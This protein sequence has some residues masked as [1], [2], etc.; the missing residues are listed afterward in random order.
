M[1]FLDLRSAFHTLLREHTFGGSATLPPRL[2]SLLEA[3]GLDAPAISQL[4][5][6]HSSLF[7]RTAR[8]AVIHSLQDAR[9]GTWYTLADSDQCHETLRGSRP[10][11]PLAD[12]AFNT[13]MV[14]VLTEIDEFLQNHVELQRTAE[15]LGIAIPL[16]A[17]ADD[18]SLPVFSLQAAALDHVLVDVVDF[19]HRTVQS[20][21]MRLNYAAGKTETVVFYRGAGSAACRTRRFVQEGGQFPLPSG[22]VLKAVEHYKHLGV[23]FGSMGCLSTDISTRIGKAAATFRQLTRSIFHSRKLKIATRLQLLESLVLSQIFF[24]CGK[25]PV[26]SAS[27]YNHLQAAITSWQRQITRCGFWQ[28]DRLTD[29]DFRAKHHLVPVSV[30]LA[31]HRIAFAKQLFRSAPA[32]VLHAVQLNDPSCEDSW[33]FAL[34][35]SLTWYRE[36]LPPTASLHQLDFSALTFEALGDWCLQDGP[37][38][39]L[40]AKTVT[41]YLH[42]EA[43]GH[44]V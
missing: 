20:Y 29:M 9:R 11:S 27:T 26:L 43:I 7:S 36:M 15:H 38:S 1:V 8:P 12:L 39:A 33:L 3:E 2:L 34:A 22:D 28:S 31:R 19:I 17:W 14:A 6:P 16:V 4:C 24:G 37:S 25:W 18:L 40:L 44:C 41:K 32:A 5:V 10:G 21:G 35:H 13:V 42:Q 30:R 23:R